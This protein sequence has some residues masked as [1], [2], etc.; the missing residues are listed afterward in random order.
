MGAGCFPDSPSLVPVITRD[1]FTRFGRVIPVPQHDTVATD[2]K[3][4]RNVQRHRL[5]CFW[6]LNFCLQW[7]RSRAFGEPSQTLWHAATPGA[8]KTWSKWGGFMFTSVWGKMD[9]TVS[10]LLVK[11][12]VGNP[13]KVTGLFS[14]V[15]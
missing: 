9:P 11:L 3:L 5:P 10:A 7:K 4:P 2:L 12:S 1:H 15:P 13:M 8:E 6:I 14:V